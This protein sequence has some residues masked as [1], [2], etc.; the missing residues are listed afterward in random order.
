MM[1]VGINKRKG[2]GACWHVVEWAWV[3]HTLRAPVTVSRETELESLSFSCQP[4]MCVCEFKLVCFYCT[5]NAYSC[6]HANV[7]QSSLTISLNLLRAIFD[8]RYT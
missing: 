7:C 4:C 2:R 8:L 5:P 1:N 6:T 3:S